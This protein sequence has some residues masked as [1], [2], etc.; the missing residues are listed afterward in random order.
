VTGTVRAWR[1][2][3]LTCTSHLVSR[4]LF[5]GFAISLPRILWED[6]DSKHLGPTTNQIAVTAVPLEHIDGNGYMPQTQ[7]HHRY[8]LVKF[9]VSRAVSHELVR[10]RPV[11]WL[12]ESQRYCRYG[13]HV[14]F[15]EPSGAFSLLAASEDD[16]IQDPNDIEP[17]MEPI[18][19]LRD[20][21]LYS[22]FVAED[23]YQYSL[24][25]GASPQQARLVLPNSCKTELYMF[26]NLTEYMHFFRLR[27]SNAAEPSMREVVRPLYDEFHAAWPWL[28]PKSYTLL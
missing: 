24:T 14:Q 9:I 10:H 15:I 27:T 4:R 21:W 20:Q 25:L 22:L 16:G 23:A 11:S 28:F 7:R 8:A 1:E 5:D 12:Q 26:A 2:F 17:V 18:V 6:I 13:D 3:F 19:T